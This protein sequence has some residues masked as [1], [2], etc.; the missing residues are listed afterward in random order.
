MPVAQAMT[1]RSKSRH[2]SSPAQPEKDSQVQQGI[3]FWAQHFQEH[4]EFITD[5]TNRYQVAL[6]PTVKA[7]LDK[8]QTSWKNVEK[9]PSYYDNRLYMTTLVLKEKVKEDVAAVPCISDL[10]DHMI[11]ELNYF[12]ESIVDGEFSLWNEIQYWSTEHAENINFVLCELPRLIAEDDS[13]KPV[14]AF[15]KP[16]SKKDKELA[17]AFEKIAKM[18]K[19]PTDV[20]EFR[21]STIIPMFDKHIKSIEGLKGKVT[22]LPLKPATRVSFCKMLHHELDEAKFAYKR[23]KDMQ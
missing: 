23:I 22:Q 2:S 18:K 12:K 6:S 21:D 7:F 3:K 9:D 8:V 4:C 17:N 10:L 1:T 14:P 16:A 20:F 15:L 19:T 11:E 13:G 5:L